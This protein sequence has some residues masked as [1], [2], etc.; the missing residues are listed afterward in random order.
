MS[1]DG[2][3]LAAVSFDNRSLYLRETATGS[4]RQCLNLGYFADLAWAVDSSF[5]QFRASRPEIE[6]N[7]LSRVSPACERPTP[8]LGLFNMEDFAGDSWFGIAPDLS[9]LGLRHAA[10]EIY[11]IDWRLRRRAP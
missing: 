1:P 9:P 6:G 4:W 2:K 8:A 5:I 7:W 3:Y 10:A 11:A